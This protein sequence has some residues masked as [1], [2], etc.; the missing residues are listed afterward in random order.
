MDQARVWNR[1]RS[2]GK[3]IPL[4]RILPG[5][6]FEPPAGKASIFDI[7]DA[8][9]IKRGIGDDGAIVDVRELQHWSWIGAAAFPVRRKEW[10]A[11][12]VVRFQPVASR[13]RSQPL[14]PPPV[15]DV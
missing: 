3:H 15:A 4:A 5:A 10:I 1:I 11:R 8:L 14:A 2:L 9:N 12:H 13:A 7:D 6:V